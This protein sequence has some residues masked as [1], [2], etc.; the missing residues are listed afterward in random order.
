MAAPTPVDL[1]KLWAGSA[2]KPCG[3]AAKAAP[4]RVTAARLNG[5]DPTE[6]CKLAR[7]TA[8]QRPGGDRN[9][10]GSSARS[11]QQR[12]GAR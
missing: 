8:A 1:G 4:L 5:C 11:S 10:R 12:P 6:T 9:G 2:V 7:R 3:L